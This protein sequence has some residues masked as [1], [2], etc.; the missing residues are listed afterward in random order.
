M[1]NLKKMLIAVIAADLGLNLLG[2]IRH[3]SGTIAAYLQYLDDIG[4]SLILLILLRAT[5]GKSKLADMQREVNSKAIFENMPCTI[6]L[7]SPEFDILMLNREGSRLSGVHEQEILGKK[8]YDVFG[9]GK[10]CEDCPVPKVMT[11]KTV[12]RVQQHIWRIHGSE[13]YVEQTAIPIFDNNGNVKCILES[14][15]NLTEQ[16]ELKNRNSNM[17]IETVSSLAKL[18]GSR[19]HSTGTHSERVCGIGLLIGKQLQLP[20][21]V[22]QEIGVAALL[23]DIGK[24]GIPE[25]ILKKQGK[26]TPAEYK[27]I[28]RHCEIGYNALK[29]IEPLQRIAEYVRYHHEAFDGSGYPFGLKGEAIPLISRILSVADVFE[30]LTADRVYRK[31][32]S[33]EQA[34]N[35]MREGR[36]KKFD[37]VVL[38]AFLECIAEGKI[39]DLQTKV[40][41]YWQQS[42]TFSHNMDVLGMGGSP[43]EKLLTIL[44]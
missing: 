41:K 44:D 2:T 37:P 9:S 13:L 34:L 16:Y 15:V 39:T 38:D 40:Q 29:D 30:A 24:I 33:F 14:A 28:Q 8:C 31:A 26:L 18:I 11:E 22:M 21:T 23:H 20:L 3:I 17:F 5:V 42:I 10:M 35:I 27:E 12:C 19:D 43:R 1:E 32:M 36:E 6:K 4:L 7:I 25:N